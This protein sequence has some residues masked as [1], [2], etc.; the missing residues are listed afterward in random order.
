LWDGA[1]ISLASG[2]PS[3][4]TV[5]VQ[6]LSLVLGMELPSDF[7]SR[8]A[9]Y[10]DWEVPLQR[11]YAN[12]KQLFDDMGPFDVRLFRMGKLISLRISMLREIYSSNADRQQDTILRPKA[13]FELE[14]LLQKTSGDGFRILYVPEHRNHKKLT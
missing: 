1:F 4:E 7:A 9:Y 11:I 12:Q 5:I 10:D 6:L 14:E 13:L 3:T 8:N 2:C